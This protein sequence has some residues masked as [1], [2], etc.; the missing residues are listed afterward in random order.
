MVLT[1]TAALR[2]RR[3]RRGSDDGV[4]AVVVA[5]VVVGVVM[6]LMAIVVDLGVTRMLAHQSRGAAD[7]AALA[8]A[9]TAKATS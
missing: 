4:V 1:R 7:A 8:A 3:R 6:P 2:S 5:I 9:G